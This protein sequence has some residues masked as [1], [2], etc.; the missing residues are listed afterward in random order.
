MSPSFYEFPRDFYIQ[1]IRQIYSKSKFLNVHPCFKAI[2]SAPFPHR[3]TSIQQVI[4]DIRS[5]ES[6]GSFT[7]PAFQP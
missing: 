2:Y 6:Y 7:H 1:R 5:L 3:T 4:A